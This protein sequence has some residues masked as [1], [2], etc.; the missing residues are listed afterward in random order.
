MQ[1]VCPYNRYQNKRY[2][3]KD[4][5]AIHILCNGFVSNYEVWRFHGEICARGSKE[6]VNTIF[7]GVI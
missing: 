2:L 5:V 4:D 7:I 6:I 1:I 3:Y